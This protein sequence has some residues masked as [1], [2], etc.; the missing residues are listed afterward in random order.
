[1]LDIP[2]IKYSHAT[3]SWG[4]KTIFQGSLMTQ[5]T[6]G[7]LIVFEGIDGTGKSTQLQMLA[8]FLRENGHAVVETREPTN[9]KFGRRIRSLYKKRRSVSL[10]EEL[11]LFLADRKE[12]VEELIKPAL[13]A[14]KIV[15]CDR[16]YLSSAAYQGA[17][18]LNPEEII[19]RN[20]FAP[21]PDLAL[22]FD[23]D[24]VVAIRRIT[25]K[26]G[27]TLNDFE[28]LDSLKKVASVFTGMQMAYIKRID[29]S[30]SAE[31][32]GRLVQHHVRTLLHGE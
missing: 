22:V 15:L 8:S 7:F 12:H 29:A 23:L 14:G 9:G 32:I 21:V 26:R 31:A 19:A 25:E 27:D 3:Q 4:K 13:S 5:L 18:G 24:P 1:M 16:Y 30:G 10:E 28:Q 6:K 2:R 11:D 17:A 20:D